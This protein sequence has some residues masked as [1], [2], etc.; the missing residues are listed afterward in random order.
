MRYNLNGDVKQTDL[1]YVSNLGW[2]FESNFG[3]HNVRNAVHTIYV[4]YS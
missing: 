2:N 4:L 3:K 1:G